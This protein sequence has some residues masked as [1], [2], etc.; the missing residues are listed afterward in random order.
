[1]AVDLVLKNCRLVLKEG[2]FEA[3]VAID[4]GKIVSIASIDHLPR[5][6]VEVDLNGRYVLP[7]AIDVHVHAYD[8]KHFGPREDF[9]SISL[10][11]SA[12]GVTTIIEMPTDTPYITADALREKIEAGERWSRI[13]FSLHAGNIRSLEGFDPNSLI[14]LGVNSFKLFLCKPYMIDDRD[15]LRLMEMVKGRG[16][17]MFHAENGFLVDLYTERLKSMDRRDPMAYHESR[18]RLAEVEGIGRVIAY[19]RATG[20]GIHIVHLTTMEGLKLIEEAKSCGVDI[21]CE[22]CPHYLIFTRDDVERL[23]PYLK[24]TPPLRLREDLEALWLGL[25]RGLIDIVATDHYS[26]FKEDREPGWSDIWPIRSGLPGIETLLPL[27]LSEGVNRGRITLMDLA[28]LLSENPARRFGLY[29][30]KGVIAIGSD[31]DLTVID[32]NREWVIK[33]DELHQRSGW[34]PYEGYMCR[35]RIYMTI[36]R[37][38]IIYRDG[39]V[40]GREGYGEYVKRGCPERLSPICGGGKA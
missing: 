11:A 3:G 2:V 40:L 33:A 7:G 22:T 19:S 13:D 32:L 5:G 39:E 17:C 4:R 37:G 16:L 27:M 36:L 8:P 28:R 18:P 10:A 34:T 26:T 25:R 21:S 1:L 31:A 30:K 12:G 35:G 9:R 38:E 23:G 24:M 29:P 15:I 14:D 20:C 6:D